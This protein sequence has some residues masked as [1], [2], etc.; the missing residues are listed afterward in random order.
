MCAAINLPKTSSKDDSSQVPAQALEVA[1]AKPSKGSKKPK[2]EAA[3]IGTRILCE[4]AL[5]SAALVPPRAG[6]A[7]VL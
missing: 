6:R 5:E 7:D 2:P 1:G 4:S 3:P